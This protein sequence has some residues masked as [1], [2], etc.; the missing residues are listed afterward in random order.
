ME[1]V[2]NQLMIII[3]NGAPGSGKT[4]TVRHLMETTLNSAA[5]DGDFLLGINP[6]NRTDEERTLRYKNIADV[7]KNYFEFGYKTIFIS[8]VYGKSQLEEQIDFLKNT[9]NVEV[10]ALVPNEETLRNRHSGDKY[11]RED[12]ESSIEL[13][14]RIAEIENIQII[15]NSNLSIEEVAGK[16]KQIAG[17]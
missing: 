11:D 4:K 16:I 5:I 15:D 17:I 7:A 9:D 6:Q 13:N 1:S 14:R 8:F 2:Y 10:F 12:I 3:V